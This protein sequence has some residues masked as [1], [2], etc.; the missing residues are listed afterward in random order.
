MRLPLHLGC[1]RRRRGPARLS[2]WSGVS[3]RHPSTFVVRR[4]ARGAEVADHPDASPS[5]GGDDGVARWASTGRPVLG[6]R[7]DSTWPLAQARI[8]AM[9]VPGKTPGGQTP[10]PEHCLPFSALRVV[11]RTNAPARVAFRPRRWRALLAICEDQQSHLNLSTQAQRG[12]HPRPVGS[13]VH[14]SEAL[15]RRGSMPFLAKSS[16]M[17]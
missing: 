11:T 1:E 10:R 9:S 13:G 3:S 14:P 16:R 2:G 5:G 4:N 12:G 17:A 8:P 15:A 6:P 7:S